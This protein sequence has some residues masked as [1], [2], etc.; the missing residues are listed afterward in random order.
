MNHELHTGWGPIYH[1]KE[2]C[3]EKDVHAMDCDDKQKNKNA[4]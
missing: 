1:M 3:I 2:M 4:L